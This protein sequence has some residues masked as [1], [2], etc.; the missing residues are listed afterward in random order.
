MESGE[1]AE[2][3]TGVEEVVAMF[4]Q[5]AYWYGGVFSAV[6]RIK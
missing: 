4:V 1:S 6:A 5:L 3:P 2:F